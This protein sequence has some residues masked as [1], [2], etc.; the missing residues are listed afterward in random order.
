MSKASGTDN[1]EQIV[2]AAKTK[3]IL[4]RL[5]ASEGWDTLQA[6]VSARA[7]AIQHSI[8]A[9]PVEDEIGIYKQEFR[10]GH[11]IGLLE[12]AKILDQVLASA[13]DVADLE[14]DEDASG[15]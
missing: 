2:E 4:S 12:V 7:M 5:K 8:L 10:K 15:E 13:E 3:E 14:D 1:E 11:A 9:F 6:I